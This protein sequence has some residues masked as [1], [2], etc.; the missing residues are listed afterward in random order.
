MF[1]YFSGECDCQVGRSFFSEG[2]EMPHL[3]E[4][5]DDYPELVASFRQW[6]FPDEVHRNGLPWRVWEFQG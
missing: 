5:I 6:E 2:D 4:P 1:P 3:G